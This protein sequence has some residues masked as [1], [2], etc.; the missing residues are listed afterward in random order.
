MTPDELKRYDGKAGRKAYV[1]VSGK[2]YNVT[3][4]PLWNDG[5]H[6]GEHQAG[7][8]L[9][10]ALKTAPHVRAVVERFTVVDE[11]SPPAPPTRGSGIGLIWVIVAVLAALALTVMLSI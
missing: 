6:Q 5:D 2:V 10:E 8:D 7:C 4:S 1:A 3:D 9:T 11:L